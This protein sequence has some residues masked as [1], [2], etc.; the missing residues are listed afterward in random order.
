M[1]DAAGIG[2]KTRVSHDQQRKLLIEQ[3]GIAEEI[4]MR[5]PENMTETR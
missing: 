3:F 1:R 5:L 2:S 4:A